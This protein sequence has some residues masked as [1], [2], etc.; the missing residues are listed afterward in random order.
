MFVPAVVVDAAAFAALSWRPFSREAFVAAL[1][2]GVCPLF[3]LPDCCVVVASFA[4]AVPLLEAEED[5]G[6]LFEPV[7]SVVLGVA[8]LNLV[9]VAL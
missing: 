1:S 4:L 9:G 2:S 6:V 3:V 7:L 5:S 8:V